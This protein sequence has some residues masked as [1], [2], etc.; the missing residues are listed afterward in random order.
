MILAQL[1]DAEVVKHQM[2]L[3][4]RIFNPDYAIGYENGGA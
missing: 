3:L 2:E 1:A 4:A